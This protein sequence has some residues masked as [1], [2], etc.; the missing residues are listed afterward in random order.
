MIWKRRIDFLNMT[1]DLVTTD[2]ALAITDDLCDQ[3]YIFLRFPHDSNIF[4]SHVGCKLV[5]VPKPGVT[6]AYVAKTDSA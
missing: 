2:F 1:I 5:V 6:G 3:S 4:R